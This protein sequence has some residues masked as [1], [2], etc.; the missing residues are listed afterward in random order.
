[1]PTKTA[2][3]FNGT[4]DSMVATALDLSAENIITVF[5][6]MKWDSYAND[7]KAAFLHETIF[8]A[9]RQGNCGVGM[10]S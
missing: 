10:F 9:G 1:M 8:Q 2:R 5:F 7:D 6:R 3:H 4:S